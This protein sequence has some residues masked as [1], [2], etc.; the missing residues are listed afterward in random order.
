MRLGFLSKETLESMAGHP[1][2][3]ETHGKTKY[4]A[5]FLQAKSREKK[6]RKGVRKILKPISKPNPAALMC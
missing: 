4:L 6:K 3:Q 2:I 1:I 5:E